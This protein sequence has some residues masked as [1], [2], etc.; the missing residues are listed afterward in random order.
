MSYGI[1]KR[2]TVNVEIF[3]LHMFLRIS[4]FFNI[5]E[6]MYT[7]T[8]TFFFFFFLHFS[9]GCIYY[10][11][12][13]HVLYT[14]NITFM[15]AYRAMHSQNANIYPRELV[16]FRRSAKI[17]KR[18]NIHVHSMKYCKNMFSKIKSHVIVFI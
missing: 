12:S 10:K 11:L 2:N 4:R 14:M 1:I 6:N 7:M 15:I 13:R 9:R 3:A 17:Y 5:R 18:E 16:Y 8:K